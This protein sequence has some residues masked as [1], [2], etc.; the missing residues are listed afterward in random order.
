MQVEGLLG[1]PCFSTAYIGKLSRTT[2]LLGAILWLYGSVASAQL[3]PTFINGNFT[4]G[5]ASGVSPYALWDT[6][7]LSSNP[8]ASKTIYLDYRGFH[9][10]NNR[11]GHNIVFDPFSLDGDVNNFSDDELIQIQRQFQNIAE[12]FLPFDVNVTTINPGIEKIRRTSAGD[13]E[14]GIRSLN[15][16]PKGGFG[17]GI[18]G[19]AYINGFNYISA[20]QNDSPAFSF[21]KGS[22]N[23]AMTNSHEVGHTLG[24]GHDG[25]DAAQYHPGVG[26]GATGWGP[27]MGAPFGKNLTQWSN[28]D[29]A[30]STNTQDDLSIIT[31]AANGFGFRADDFG[32]TLFT[33]SSLTHDNGVV[34]HWG[35]VERNTDLDFFSFT[36]TAG[37]LNLQI[38]PFKGTP[39]LDIL[40]SLYN[41]AGVLLFSS[42]PLEDVNAPINFMLTQA[43]DY[44][45]SIDGVGKPGVYSNYGSLGFYN[46]MGSFS[47]VP[48]PSSLVFLGVMG[49]A[50]ALVRRR[51]RS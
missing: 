12:D 49:V 13:T 50:T 11:W 5:N 43:G 41:S 2:V 1:L 36:A 40:A 26:S 44:F 21:N 31:K 37:L 45:L 8:T 16:Q 42:N 7:F 4:I 14:Y 24:L 23:G 22:N 48:E 17:N 47:A 25:V 51:N 18:G 35:I 32:S 38:D 34:N 19:V 30:N 15:T 10:V 27:I 46:I 33:A 6:F 20:T 3:F 39:N 28:G 9:S 29:Y